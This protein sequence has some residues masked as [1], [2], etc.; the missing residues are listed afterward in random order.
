MTGTELVWFTG[1]LLTG[2]AH[3]GSLWAGA[4]DLGRPGRGAATRLG[5][6]SV[7]LAA[8]AISQQLLPAAAGWVCGLAVT[9]LLLYARN[10]Q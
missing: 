4:R 6:V 9:A 1:G 8:S 2:I 3:A 10:S 7:T 5:L